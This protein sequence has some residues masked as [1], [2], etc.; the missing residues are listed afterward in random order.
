[1]NET[2]SILLI[3]HSTFT[4]V[5]L[6]ELF[7]NMGEVGMVYHARDSRKGCVTFSISRIDLLVLSEQLAQA[8]LLELA[9][10]CKV[11]ECEL[12]LLS[13]YTHDEYR[14]WCNKNGIAYLLDKASDVNQLQTI[15]KEIFNSKNSNTPYQSSRPISYE[16]AL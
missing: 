5:R 2:V 16:K 12:I 9:S 8:E 14:K 1:M 3:D 7:Q 4:S 6:V 10:L 15:I 11:F 13:D